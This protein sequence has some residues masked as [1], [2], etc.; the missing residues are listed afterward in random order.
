[1]AIGRSTG[2][3]QALVK[4]FE[5]LKQSIRVPILVIQ[6]MPATFTTI[7]AQHIQRASGVEC[8]EGVDGEPLVNGRI[9]IAPWVKN[10]F[11]G[12]VQ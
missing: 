7:L 5:Y 8:R 10:F 3:P 6:H 1:M 9:Y 2:G 12:R 11:K 4:V